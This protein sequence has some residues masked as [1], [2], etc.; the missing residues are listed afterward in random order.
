MSEAKSCDFYGVT[1]E[2]DEHTKIE[3]AYVWTAGWYMDYEGDVFEVH[4]VIGRI[5]KNVEYWWTY[6]LDNCTSGNCETEAEAIS[7]IE[8]AHWKDLAR[9]KA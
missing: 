1:R 6:D 3:T 9:S 5:V 7:E 4:Q 8:H 2:M